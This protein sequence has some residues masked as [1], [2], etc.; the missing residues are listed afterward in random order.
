MKLVS[1]LPLAGLAALASAADIT[2]K[3]TDTAVKG[4][5]VLTDN[6]KIQFCPAGDCATLG[7]TIAPTKVSEFKTDGTTPV[8]TNVVT[9]FAVTKADVATAA[10]ADATDVKK[11]DNTVIGKSSKYTT[12]LKA[13]DTELGV[14][15]ISASYYYVATDISYASKTLKVPAGGVKFTAKITGWAFSTAA[16][17]TSDSNKVKLDFAITST[18]KASTAADAAAKAPTF[19]TAVGT[20]EISWLTTI[21]DGMFLNVPEKA[22]SGETAIA[23][24]P[25]LTATASPYTLSLMIDNFK[26]KTLTYDPVMY[27]TAPTTTAPTTNTTNNT[28]STTTPAPSGTSSVWGYAA[29]V[30]V[31]AAAIAAMMF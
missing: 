27:Y 17:D 20:D 15:E 13:G 31:G 5:A 9:G 1:L 18:V 11:A 30:F 24:K 8:A 4:T 7:F 26:G 21:G 14:L 3:S 28:N 6:G 29:S 2:L 10:W 23:S 25:T 12:V 22:L 16:T 19:A